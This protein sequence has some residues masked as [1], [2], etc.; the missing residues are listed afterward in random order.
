MIIK[1]LANI[2]SCEFPPVE[3]MTEG[4]LLQFPKRV[5]LLKDDDEDEEEAELPPELAQAAREQLAS[6]LTRVQYL[7]WIKE[8]V[9]EDYLEILE[10]IACFEVF[11]NLD[12]DLQDIVSGFY[13]LRA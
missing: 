12:E 1:M 4:I 2:S 10:G 8:C 9:P 3:A 11:T 6:P 13:N 7:K 5:T